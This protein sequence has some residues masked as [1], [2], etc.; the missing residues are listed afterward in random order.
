MIKP[1]IPSNEKQRLE[2]LLE[3]NILDTQLEKSFDDL[4]A[5]AAEI[6]ETPISLVSLIDQTR[7]WFKSRHGLDAA[8]TPR[9]LSFCA[10]AINQSE[11]F[12]VRDS[13]LDER[14]SDNP[15][16]T[17]E[18]KVVFYAG[19][20]L[21]TAEKYA[22]GTLCVVDHKPRSLTEFQ[23]RA[24]SVLAQQ[25]VNQLELRR[26]MLRFAKAKSEIAA[27]ALVVTY[28]HQINN[29]LAIAM[30]GLE[31]QKAVI[32]TDQ[33]N[34][35]HGSLQRIS[36]MLKKIEKT[37]QENGVELTNYADISQMLKIVK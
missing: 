15:L 1:P 29:P 3:L 18:V 21:E 24:L 8:E 31:Q 27:A 32:P 35:I 34:T 14:F 30:L 16:V 33:F 22:L 36:E 6:C 37:V 5:L 25:V 9:E 19:V 26:S 23:K 12:E 4:T 7:Q 28:N 2:S 20:P 17:G 13:R 11:L 10:H